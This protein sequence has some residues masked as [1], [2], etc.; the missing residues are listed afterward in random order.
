[1]SELPILYNEVSKIEAELD[2]I[3]DDFLANPQ[4]IDLDGYEE[5]CRYMFAHNVMFMRAYF[6]FIWK[7]E[8]YT[9]TEFSDILSVSLAT[10]KKWESAQSLPNRLSVKS[11]LSYANETLK[12]EEPL[13]EAHLLCK[14]FVLLFQQYNTKSYIKS[15]LK[16]Y[17]IPVSDSEDIFAL[18]NFLIN[19]AQSSDSKFRNY[20]ENLPDAYLITNKNKIVFANRNAIDIFGFKE[21]SDIDGKSIFDFSL[22]EVNVELSEKTKTDEINLLNKD[23]QTKF[24]ETNLNKLNKSKFNA[25]ISK[26]IISYDNKVCVQYIIRD[27]TSQL[28]SEKALKESEK[29]YRFVANNLPNSFLV[30]YDKNLNIVMVEGSAIQRI[31]ADKKSAIGKNLFKTLT[32]K[33]TEKYKDLFIRALSGEEN[34]FEYDFGGCTYNIKFAPIKDDNNEITSAMALAYEVTT[35]KVN[36]KSLYEDKDKLLKSIEDKENEIKSLNERIR[37]GIEQESKYQSELDTYKSKL[38]VMLKII[39]MSV[40]VTDLDGKITQY[41]SK[42]TDKLFTDELSIG[43]SIYDKL[44]LISSNSLNIRKAL[45]GFES[46][47]IF[48]H[49]GENYQIYYYPYS[50]DNINFTG[51][52]LFIINISRLSK[53]YSILKA[54]SDKSISVSTTGATDEVNSGLMY[55]ISEQKKNLGVLQDNY[56]KMHQCFMDFPSPLILLDTKG[57]VTD[58]NIQAE[59]FI[60]NEFDGFVKLQS[61]FKD[62]LSLIKMNDMSDHIKSALEG[63]LINTEYK[64]K[65]D[66]VYK[67]AVIPIKVNGNIIGACINLA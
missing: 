56:N 21:L 49:N 11:L 31:I 38:S 61:N 18:L 14:N 37:I 7:F 6:G 13:K 19:N 32:N 46:N 26:S 39:P 10:L 60:N 48:E 55:L 45:S 9:Q 35:F 34:S 63:N 53:A 65:S 24:I 43:N 42:E 36:E 59:G 17:N 47:E 29:N 5:K 30:V 40:I 20:L 1:M 66:N 15:I 23:V 50:K 58:I 33:E 51:T 67:I 8:A 54:Q 41:N 16:Q 22:P 28:I 44:G 27:I 57:S 64:F 25:L 2:V 3:F 4:T 52:L 62:I 12:I